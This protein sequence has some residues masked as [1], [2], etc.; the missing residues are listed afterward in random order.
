MDETW[1]RHEIQISSKELMFKSNL[2]ITTEGLDTNAEKLHQDFITN[3]PHLSEVRNDH[4]ELVSRANSD[5][6]AEK[7]S[8][9]KLLSL[10][11]LLT[12]FNGEMNKKGF[13]LKVNITSKD[14]VTIR[15][16]IQNEKQ[17]VEIISPNIFSGILRSFMMPEDCQIND[18]TLEDGFLE[19]SFR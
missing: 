1:Q 13:S 15:S 5:I 8:K 4:I 18:V 3:L 19:F 6:K 2:K 11:E 12:E 7:L 9:R 16:K 10:N 14:D 17:L